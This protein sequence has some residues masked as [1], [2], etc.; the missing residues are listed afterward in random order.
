MAFSLAQ[1]TNFP[2][3]AQPAAGSLSVIVSADQTSIPT[4][5][6]QLPVLL[7]QAPM[8]NSLAVVV[9]GDQ[10]N[11]PVTVQSNNT[12]VSAIFSA[13]N[14]TQV[15][16][17]NGHQGIAFRVSGAWVGT[18]DFEGS[19]DGM[20]TWTPIECFNPDADLSEGVHSFTNA[21]GVF[22]P[23]DLGGFTHV[24]AIASVWSS[25]SANIYINGNNWAASP[26]ITAREDGA[27]V[28]S[29]GNQMA[30][31]DGGGLLRFVST[32]T[33][34]HLL[35]SQFGTWTIGLPTGAATETTLAGVLT[36]T[37]F[38]TRIPTVGQKTMVGSIPVT[39]AS[40]QGALTVATH[41]VTGSGTF[42]VTGTFWQATQPISAAALP[43]PTGAS[44]EATLSAMS[45]KLPATLGQK[46][47]VASMAVAI[48]SDQSSLPV[49]GTFW[50]A[51]QP[52]SIAAAVT[53]Q[54]NKTYT[55]AFANPTDGQDA[56][57]FLMGFNGTT[58]DRVR[59][60]NTGRL[61]V[62][63]VT[64]GGSN[65]S[66]GAT[67]AAVPASATFA[68][69]QVVSSTPTYANG[70]LQGLTLDTSGNLRVNVVAGGGAGGTSSSFTAAFPGTGTAAGA[71]VTAGA[72][73][74]SAGNMQALSVDT[75]G[76]LK[77]NVV[78]GGGAGGTSSTFGAVVP[79]TGTA[80]GFSDGTN[81]VM[82]RVGANNADAVASI[83]AGVLATS[84]YLMG[85]N[86]TTWDR[87]R[88]A[89]TGRLQVDVVTGGGSN[90]SVGATGAAMPASATAVGGTDGVN[91][92]ALSVSSTGV[93]NIQGGTTPADTFANPTVAIASLS[94]LAG[95]NGTTWDRLRSTTA[96][97]LAVDVT[98]V[99]GS[100][101]VTGTFWQATQPISAAALPLPTGASTEATLSAMS[102]KL[103]AALGP[104][105]SAA[106]LSVTPAT[107][108]TFPVTQS[109]TWTVQPG[110][111]ANT[112]AWLVTGTGGTFPVTG[113]FW[114]ATQ[115]VSIAAAVTAVG[116]KT[117]TDA[118]ANPTDAQDVMGFNMGW[119][120]TTWDRLKSTTANG[121]VVDVSRV[122][123]SVAVTGTF[124]QATQPVSG[125]VAAT[126]SGT[127][128][129]QPGNTA[130]TTPWLVAGNVT[131]ADA[132]ANPTADVP[133]S[134]YLMGFNGTTWDRVRTA[135]TGRLQ[136]D[137]VT[138]GGSNASVGAT[139][140]AVP[141][142]ATLSGA[143]VTTGA[144]AYSAGNMNPLSIDASGYLKVNVAAG[145]AAGGTSSSFTAAFPGTGTAAG[146]LVTAGAQAYSAGNMQA[147]SVDTSGYL[148]VNVVA[149]GGAGGTSSSFAAA[150]PGTGTAAGFSDGTNM[151]MAR[152]G[153]NNA[154]AVA[155]LTAGVLATS[156]YLM[157]YNGTT[158]DRVRTA[159]T[160]RLQVDV[161]TGGGSNAS[162][163][164]TGS[165]PPASGTY[166][167]GSVTTAAPTYTTGTLAGLS[168]NLSGGL[169]VDGSGVT[170][171]VS[172]ASMP[173]TPVTGT[174]WQATQPISA[175]ALPLP[176]GAATET[177]LAAMS[178][179]LPAALGPQ[180]SASSLSVTPATGAT[181]PVTQSGTW[182]VQ[183]GNTANT[184]PWLVAGNVTAADAFANPTT[185]APVSGF[186]MGFNGTTWDRVRTANTGRL[187]VDVVTGGGSNASV[188]ATGAAVPASG[189][190]AGMNV[191]GNLVGLTGTGTALN[192]NVASFGGAATTLG[193]KVMASS[194]PV[195]IA[196][197][198]FV[199][200]LLG[201]NDSGNS[202][203]ANL[204]IG[205]TFTGTGLDVFNYASVVVYA[206]SNVSSAANGVSLQWSS[207]SVNWDEV[208]T[209]TFT[210]GG[211]ALTLVSAHRG[212]YFRVVYT[213]GGTGQTS[214]RLAVIQ[215]T[216]MGGGDLLEMVDPIAQ[217]DHAQLVRGILAAKNAAGT[218][219]ADL[220]QVTAA[221]A[222]TNP[223]SALSVGSF[224]MGY[225]GTT[226]D[227]L[228]STTANGLAVDVTRVQGSVA[229]TGTFWQATQPVS[230][231][232][233]VAVTQSGT[234]T[235]QPGNTANTTAWLV[236]GNKTYT[237]AFANP[238]DGQDAGAF[239]MGFNGTTWDR[240]RTANTGRLQVDVVTGGGSNA[241]VGATGSAPPASATLSGGSVTTAAPTY[242]TGQMAALSLDTAGNLRV[243]GSLSVVGST[244]P[245]DAFAN[246]TNAN[247]N[248]ALLA[249]FNGTTWDRL[250]TANSGRL[251]VDVVTGGGSNASV[252]ATGSAPPASATL[253]G[254]SVTT[255]APTYTTGQMSA[256]SLDTGGSLRVTVTNPS[257]ASTVGA[258]VPTTATL[259]GFTDGTNLQA[260]R[261]GA[262][263]ADAVAT[264]TANV[265]AVSGYLMGWNGTTWDRLKSTTANGLAVDVTRSVLP[266][267]ASTEASLA[268]LTIAQSAALGTNTQTMVGGSVTTAAPTYTTGQISPLSLD[269]AGGLRVSSH[270]VTGSGNFTVVGA[271]T[272]ADAFANPTTAVVA[273]AFNSVFNGTT[274]DRARGDVLGTWVQGGIAAGSAISTEKPVLVGGSDGTNVQRIKLTTDGDVVTVNKAATSAVT[275][276][277][278]SATTVTLKASN[279]ARKGLTVMN[280][281]TAILY[282]KLGATASAT[283]YTVKMA[284]GAYYELPFGYSGVVDGIWASANGF[285]YVTEITN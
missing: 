204:G 153:A 56:G 67:A 151:V 215:K 77:V 24:R 229:V 185:N 68:A 263:N 142:S 75:S 273:D 211:N 225:N 133:V 250:R 200:T 139:S 63:V 240:V 4:T 227:R 45:A 212:R 131:A 181:F 258:A 90:A 272:L 274:W 237:D 171:P 279:T 194:I 201:L 162:V 31:K 121:L 169:R 64:G 183:P 19:A 188:S 74:Y 146:A 148:K 261:V 73:A 182:T 97:G 80:A 159:N 22:Q 36:N 10:T 165:A 79:G 270:A 262:N 5:S 186:L 271:T 83:A 96:N 251:Q 12:S 28:P 15:M 38:T 33:A 232:A 179:K 137:V 105:A 192:T 246:P 174:F 27:S 275:Q 112:T 259:V 41:A 166:A 243:A 238:T 17:V 233:A 53:A 221:D 239:L 114:Q 9:S 163:G 196:S 214:F 48:A 187:Q 244:T 267:G 253:G 278:S 222:L 108:A 161:V 216:A 66:V 103:P 14:A 50:Q 205:A 170:Q 231:A 220:Q 98:R 206:F 87:V 113:T 277:T 69:A 256:L 104:Q 115:P 208:Y 126:Q 93:L 127:W 102:A 177:T 195:T 160:G 248:F 11:I 49:T 144:Q 78:A 95:F 46:A 172:I 149:G 257:A 35:V 16:T 130:N 128:T 40:D 268:K 58:W 281:S 269:T 43:L 150:V 20:V 89:N 57:A 138:G 7:G 260:A 60:A 213:N 224:L 1:V 247:L 91:L 29:Y 276:V 180:A 37:T 85:Y 198:Q 54:G 249:G 81:M 100:V 234:W 23:L 168:L 266:T 147:L 92:R 157:G 235:V 122:Q 61:Q 76:Y 18:I 155:S 71:L 280:D 82:G 30:G 173:S 134:G 226:W 210:A 59:T 202:S 140:A 8:A 156:G 84:G 152:A 189:T 191:G 34:G 119:N 21:N 255:A 242:T 99:Q 47:M 236:G 203:T 230:I 190:Y 209:E 2:L 70:N 6:A 124:W 145:G 154:D 264:L 51:T 241:S 219:V 125:T 117:P 284:A 245:A 44:T 193:Q 252:G 135:N 218:S 86:G 178:A 176:T 13:L 55:D 282:L 143:L 254:G 32:D 118:F 42:A 175:A 110:N 217:N 129:V 62:D 107:G 52:V 132:Q 164:A 94:L 223:T 199:T 26:N 106:S 228:R 285:A 109:G 197:D 25:G 39:I 141:A 111:T 101:A 120:G 116:N 123:G 167:T 88:T 158:W 283:S 207:D 136:V 3:G 184:T 65:A 72:Q 265:L